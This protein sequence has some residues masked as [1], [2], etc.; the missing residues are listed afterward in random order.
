LQLQERFKTIADR[1]GKQKKSIDVL[2][3][4]KAMVDRTVA[5]LQGKNAVLEKELAEVKEAKDRYAQESTEAR[6]EVDKQKGIVVALED[7]LTTIAATAICKAKAELF[8]Q[9]LSGNH[10]KWDI[11]MMK[12]M[13][14][15][16]EE[17]KMMEESSPGQDEQALVENATPE[18][19][20]AVDPPLIDPHLAEST[21][22][23]VPANPP[24][25]TNV[26]SPA[27]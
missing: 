4:E 3:I 7:R 2:K 16:Y 25:A 17:M 27:T 24:T 20:N 1:C 11:D 18:D 22:A 5:E 14:A 23:A 8:Q 26:D 10:D 15:L 13:V 12:E 21:A 6:A 9:Y 19:T